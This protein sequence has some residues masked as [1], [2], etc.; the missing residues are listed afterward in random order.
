MVCITVS[1]H[2]LTFKSLF[3]SLPPLLFC[4]LP[5]A[6]PPVHTHTHTHTNTPTRSSPL[7]SRT[8]I[9]HRPISSL[10]VTIQ[11][12]IPTTG[13]SSL[14]KPSAALLCQTASKITDQPFHTCTSPSH[15]HER[16]RTRRRRLSSTAADRIR[17]PWRLHQ[18]PSGLSHRGRRRCRTHG[19]PGNDGRPS[20]WPSFSSDAV[21]HHGTCP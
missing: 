9:P 13:R 15:A 3:S 2:G 21:G 20:P 6:L 8:H 17:W 16:R 18:R 4:S 14:S 19:K 1:L 7:S 5:F 12:S 10:H 11:Q